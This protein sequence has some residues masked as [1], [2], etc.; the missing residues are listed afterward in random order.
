MNKDYENFY[1]I[2]LVIINILI[3]IDYYI[4]I[5]KDFIVI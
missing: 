4:L 2:I 3:K 1:N 5:R